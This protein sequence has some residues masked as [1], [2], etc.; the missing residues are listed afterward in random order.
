MCPTRFGEV[1]PT[2]SHV[3]ACCMDYYVA[4]Q[5]GSR[6]SAIERMNDRGC[7]RDDSGWARCGELVQRPGIWM[8]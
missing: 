3:D 8:C 4:L 6:E 5:V 7:E 1:P 2:M